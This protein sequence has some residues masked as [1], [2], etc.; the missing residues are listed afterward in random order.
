[1]LQPVLLIEFHAA[2]G[3][4]AVIVILLPVAI[5]FTSEKYAGKSEAT[6]SLSAL[7]TS[8]PLASL[9]VILTDLIE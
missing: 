5:S 6:G 9:H 3:T 7:Y 1:M 2:V 8:L 4:E